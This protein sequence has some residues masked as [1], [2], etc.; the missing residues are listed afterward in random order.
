MAWRGLLVEGSPKSY[1]SLVKNRPFD[2]TANAA[3]CSNRTTVHYAQ[4]DIGAVSGI[5]E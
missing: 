4:H 1:A 3:I 2:I 5:I